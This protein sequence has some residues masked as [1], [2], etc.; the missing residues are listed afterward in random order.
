[1]ERRDKK[2]KIRRAVVTQRQ[3][4]EARVRDGRCKVETG[5]GLDS[6]VPGIFG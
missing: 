2:L 1:M 4:R 6:P 3:S 5:S